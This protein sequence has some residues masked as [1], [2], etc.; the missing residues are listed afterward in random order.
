MIVS[1]PRLVTMLTA[2]KC[3]VAM[4]I[5]VSVA[6]CSPKPE[7]LVPA[8]QKESQQFLDALNRGDEEHITSKLHKNLREKITIPLGE[9]LTLRARGYNSNGYR[10][11]S[12][13]VGV[14]QPPQQAGNVLVSFVPV[15]ATVVPDE[16]V[17]PSQMRLFGPRSITVNSYLVAVSDD[18]GRNWTFFEAGENR[19]LTEALLPEAAS[20]LVFPGRMAGLET[21]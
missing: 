2:L 15:A 4:V 13:E 12:A 20:S 7:T 10:L 6:G 1:F 8:I 5:A 14:P 17:H 16:N 18:R 9:W 11:N 3:S 19:Q 21:N